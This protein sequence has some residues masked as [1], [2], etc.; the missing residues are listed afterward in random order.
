MAEIPN[1]IVTNDEFEQEHEE[2]VLSKT[3]WWAVQISLSVVAL[4]TNFIFLLTIIYNRSV[5]LLAFVIELHLDPLC[6]NHKTFETS[7]KA[8][9]I[10]G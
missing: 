9:Y 5:N 3:W 6:E 1:E 7:N 4:V 8:P 10:Q 2:L